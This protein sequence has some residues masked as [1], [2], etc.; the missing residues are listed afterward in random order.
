MT[1]RIKVKLSLL[2]LM[3]ALALGA[4]APAAHAFAYNPCTIACAS[5]YESCQTYC[6]PKPSCG[7]QC[8]RTEQACLATC[9]D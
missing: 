2:S 9:P 4:L 8:L 6:T 3:T 5:E 1:L 7:L